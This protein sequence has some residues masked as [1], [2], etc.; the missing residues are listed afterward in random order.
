M[1]IFAESVIEESDLLL[2]AIHYETNS[3]SCSNHADRYKARKDWGYEA[4]F[5]DGVGG[6]LE[7]GVPQNFY[8]F[9]A[10]RGPVEPF[11]RHNNGA[12][13][14]FQLDCEH[15]KESEKAWVLCHRWCVFGAST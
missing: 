12:G 5:R 13:D 9:D 3:S 7:L 14:L 11:I 10:G 2:L 15:S 8:N 6:A 1:L 4:I